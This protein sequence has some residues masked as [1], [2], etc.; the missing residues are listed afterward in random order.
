VSERQ[1]SRNSSS[2]DQN[3]SVLD[4]SLVKGSN[5]KINEQKCHGTTK[6]VKM[7]EETCAKATYRERRMK[8][9]TKL[10]AGADEQSDVEKLAR[11]SQM[12]ALR[13]SHC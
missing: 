9:D 8:N 4:N 7:I 11:E 3:E 12:A 5:K 1:I 13:N 10:K 2:N 6:D